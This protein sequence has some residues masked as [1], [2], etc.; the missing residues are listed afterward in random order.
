[1][2]GFGR[3]EHASEGII[4]RVEI[5]TVNR[6]QAD[7]HFSLPRELGE[8]EAGLKKTVLGVVSRGRVNIS[9]NLERAS[10]NDESLNLDPS[11]AQALEAAF[12][13]LSDVLNR[14]VK[15]EASDFLRAPGVI[16]FE[17]SGW[18]VEE[19]RTAIEPA[20]STAL[21]KLVEMRTAEGADLKTDLLVRLI[22]LEDHAKII[23]V[24]TPK[25]VA[26]Q[27]EL[28]HNRLREA[29]IDLDL[30]D[31]RL[32]KE[33][34]IFAERCD[35]SEETTRL[36]SHIGRFREYLDS[37]EPVGRSLDFLCQELNR[38]FNTIGSKANDSGIGQNVVGAKTELEKIR[39]QVQNIE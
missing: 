2:T 14:T 19:A 12:I 7:I 30:N 33:I 21:E 23:S 3:A 5:A 20:L 22:I 24:A 27:R 32:L 37:D 38:E 35:I 1:M 29:D 17:D 36:D 15:L 13:E 31:E 18:D 8:L 34:A 39:E 9:I 11:R 6:K 26:R 4:A 16:T 25:V 10:G 28:L